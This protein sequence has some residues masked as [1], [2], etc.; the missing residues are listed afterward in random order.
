MSEVGPRRFRLPILTAAAVFAV[1]G[2]AVVVLSET[3][4]MAGDVVQA[5]AAT[6]GTPT[7]GSGG[8]GGG[9]PGAPAQVAAGASRA[10][11]GDPVDV[12]LPVIAR[13]RA[14]GSAPLGAPAA[15]R[16][17]TVVCPQGAVPAVMLTG[18]Q[19][20]PP[21]IG[22]TTFGAGT[23]RITVTGTVAN[24]TTAAITIRA[25]AL[26]IAGR[27]WTADVTRPAT[28][29]AQSSAPLRIEGVYRSPS[30]A[31]ASIKTDLDWQWQAPALRACGEKGLVEDD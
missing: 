10:P 27:A 16:V 17:G 8:A 6:G 19:F 26:T 29:P 2:V 25:I 18:S 3:P 24:E 5:A 9:K 23:Y 12:R 7:A 15:A 21:L 28:L 4:S 20:V 14:T 31:A 30:I 1:I 11:S 22:G 13:G